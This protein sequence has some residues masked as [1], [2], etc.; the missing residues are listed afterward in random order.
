MKIVPYANNQDV[1]IHYEVEGNGPSLVLLHGLNGN[2]ERFRI[3]GYV[4][5][6]K[7]KY[8]LILID[9]RGHGTS[10]KPHEPEAYKMK[11]LVADIV[12]VLDQLKV[13]KAHFL[14]Y[15]IGGGICFGFAKY[16][17]ERFCSMIIGGAHPY[18]LTA[19]DQAWLDSYIQLLKEG[20][21]AVIAD[22][23]KKLGPEMTP[24][25][26]AQLMAWLDTEALVALLM[27]EDYTSSF[28]EVVPTLKVPC[29]VYAGEKDASYSSVRKCAESM[30][31]TTFVSLPNLDHRGA[32][33]QSS[34]ILPHVLKFLEKVSR[35]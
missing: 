20:K 15:S 17:S 13:G 5:P 11:T 7:E 12:A 29:L 3:Y 35:T 24:K 10:D 34:I 19:D 4:E 18:K 8:Q 22:T 28:E 16:A 27:S 21:D 2:L 33:V 9:V 32:F 6:L 31:N 23:E 1:Q 14:G 25:Y 26:R 30:P